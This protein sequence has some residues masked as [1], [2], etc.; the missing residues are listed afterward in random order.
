MADNNLTPKQEF[1]LNP[2]E[3]HTIT[4]AGIA[5]FETNLKHPVKVTVPF[6]PIQD[7]HGYDYPY[8]A[9]AS[10]NLIPDGED[11]SNGYV[12]GYYLANDGTIAANSNYYVSEYFAVDEN[13]TYTWSNSIASSAAN[14]PSIAFYDENKDMISAVNANGQRSI[15]MTPP[16]GAVYARSSQSKYNA[17]TLNKF[18][19]EIGS[20]ATAYERYSNI[21]PVEG[22]TEV[23]IMNARVNLMDWAHPFR[24]GSL[25]YGVGVGGSIAPGSD[26]NIIIT[27][28]DNGV[29]FK[30][31]A[32]WTGVTWRSPDLPN[33]TYHL[34]FTCVKDSIYTGSSGARDIFIVNKNNIIKRIISHNA[35]LSGLLSTSFS[36]SGDETAIVISIGG[37][38][39]TYG[40]V[41]M[42][43][44]MLEIGTNVSPYET[45]QGSTLPISWQDEAGTVYGGSF[46]LNE[47]GS[48]DLTSNMKK[49]VLSDLT[50]QK[51]TTGASNTG[52]VFRTSKT[53]AN[54][55]IDSIFKT[56]DACSSILKTPDSV[57][58]T[59]TEWRTKTSTDGYI[60]RGSDYIYAKQKGVTTLA[61]F[62]AMIQDQVLVS[63]LSTPI[64]YHIPASEVGQFL[65]QI[66][67]NNIWSD[68]G[69]VTL[70]YL[71]Q[72]SET[73][74]EYRGDRALELRRRAMIADAPTIHTTVGSEETGGL[75]SFKSYVKAP[76]KKIEIPFAPKQDLHGMPNPYPA[77]AS[78][79]LIS[80]GTDTSNGYVS[81]YFFLDTGEINSASNANYCISEYAEILPDTI[82]TWS[83]TIVTAVGPA[84]CFY[85][86]N[87]T[88]ISGISAGGVASHTFTSPSNAKYFRSSQASPSYMVSNPAS[89]FQL[90]VGSTATAYRRYSNICPISGWTGC[91]IKESGKN[92][93]DPSIILSKSII[94]SS[95][96]KIA[97]HASYK[98]F[99]FKL[100]PNTNYI[101][102]HARGATLVFGLTKVMPA[103]NV[104]C[105]EYIVLTNYNSYAFN[106][107]DYKYVCLSCA[108]STVQ[109][110]LQL[111]QTATSYQAF[112]G[113]TIPITFTDPSTG[114][115]VTVYGGTITINPDGSADVVST[116][117][118]IASYDSE[119]LPGAWIS[120]MDVY[121][122]GTTPTTGAQVVYELAT[123]QTYHF[124]NLEQLKT[125]L[126]D[127]NFWSDISD[128]I[129]V[130]YWNR[131]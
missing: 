48:A 43:N 124:S 126:G 7:L 27:E 45:Y 122:E 94:N 18:Q 131:G 127:N 112:K 3:E 75:A 49:L 76:V 56:R 44:P 47:D 101:V 96:K 92:L 72:N 84:I 99:Y 38:S 119:T 11:T 34:S 97:A 81:G 24:T 33:G 125:F 114:D 66:G 73:G 9:G 46:T 17:T 74:V 105:Y 69:N 111:G 41:H 22:R 32:G 116:M 110:Q 129:T 51:D 77:G 64:T 108:S 98:V 37:R 59:L 16:E 89:G 100:K 4:D 21:C 130:K 88:Y 107:G 55:G 83:N 78:V 62:T 20:T 2:V 67:Q 6:E 85:D 63:R 115:P 58:F 103:T 1:L 36:L 15:T 50:W 91:E 121:A 52:N 61:D 60:G 93:L 87:K 109:M 57:D 117:G 13:T 70:K 29:D 120:S 53:V 26:S 82:Y 68:A 14:A 5:S 86:E 25:Y 39:G 95:S 71:T 12:D 23:D 54:L 65:T 128:D 40:L 31:V 113:K 90:E 102:S 80:D 123:P 10:V 35:V 79:N 28:T 19:L 118:N 8:P 104:Q 30:T 106:S 42:T